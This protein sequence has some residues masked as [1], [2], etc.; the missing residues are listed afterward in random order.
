[1]KS[2][3]LCG[4]IAASAAV[5]AMGAGEFNAPY[6]GERLSRIAFPVGGMGAGMYCVEGYGAISTMSVK[7]RMEFFNEPS[8]FAALCVLGE[9]GTENVARVLEG[10]IPNWKYFGMPGTGRGSEGRTYGFPRFRECEFTARFPFATVALRDKAVPLSVDLTAWSPFTPPD[11]DSSSLPAGALEYTF[12]NT[13]RKAVKAV[14]S[15]NTRNFMGDNNSSIG[16]VDGGFVLYA[17]GAKDETRGR[18]G[19]FAVFVDEPGVSVDHCWFKGGWWDALTIA[20]NSVSVGRVINNPPV[21]SYA[22]G[23]SLSVPFELKP[24]EARTIRLNTCWYVPGTDQRYGRVRGPAAASAPAFHNGSS[25]GGTSGQQPV[26]GF[27]G[28]GLVNTFDPHGD[29][30]TGTL[31]SPE[32]AVTKKFVHFLIGGGDHAGKTCLDLQV[33]GKVVRSATGERSEE[34]KWKTFDVSQWVGQKAKLQIVDRETEGWGHINVDHIVFS[35]SSIGDIMTGTGNE[36]IRDAARVVIFEEFEGRDFGK[37]VSDPP[38]QM[39]RDDDSGNLADPDYIPSLYTPWYS[40]RFKSL[41]G[42]TD[43]WRRNVADL[44]KRSSQFSDAFY[45]TSLPPEAVE[46]IAANIT[47]LKS[48]TV[49]RQHDGRLWCWEGCNDHGGSCDGTCSHVWNYAQ[50][51][52]RL[53]PSME[54]GLRLTQFFEGQDDNGRQAFR[55]NLPISPG[56]GSFD[57]IDGHCGEIMA[58]HREWRISGDKA[59]LA[60]LWP[61]VKIAIDYA[62]RT[63]DPGETGLPEESHHNTYDINYFGPDGHCGSFYIGA[64]AAS[65]RMG[66][67]MGED[68][69]RYREL[70]AKG[71]ERMEKEL[72]NGEYFIQIVKKEGLKNNFGPINPKD[73]SEAYREIAEM[74]NVDGPK[75]QYGTGCLSDGVLGFWMARMCHIDEDLIDPKMVRSH[76]LAVHKYNLKRDLSQHAN[77]QRPSYALGNDGGLLLCS[78][79]RGGKPLLPFVYSDEVWTGIEYQVASHLISVGEVDKGLEIVRICR[80]RHDG[81]RRNPFNEYECGHW[82]ARAMAS[83]ALIETITGVYYDAVDKTLR[84]RDGAKSSRSFIS[85]DTGFGTVTVK[86]GKATVTPVSGKIEIK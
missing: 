22:P 73:Q 40:V 70:L 49:L 64:L 57:A 79:P 43:Y 46:A 55:K 59:W 23:A 26:A 24:G 1:M 47:I 54:R 68:V 80:K 83:Y 35:D 75:Y 81:T 86:S 53:F 31:T 56:G 11:A 39:E 61:K 71:R 72:F 67:E 60:K 5:V 12:K 77:P 66:A 6:K 76:L 19:A 2:R 14:F 15:F 36:I 18:G 52:S 20:W 78:W 82:Y 85:T 34:L 21:D 17:R 45:D 62:I 50:A 29:T 41:Q 33:D 7:H 3:V 69:T 32:F 63:W 51:L 84:L 27:L 8:C 37:W 42:V 25:R 38:L 30:A 28:R 4:L 44:R 65:A 58:V 10:P 48:P 74:V 9:G 13:S 16:A